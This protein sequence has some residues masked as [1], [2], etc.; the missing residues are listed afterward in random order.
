M[1]PSANPG[2]TLSRPCAG[3]GIQGAGLRLPI[4]ELG[5]VG[6]ALLGQVIGAEASMILMGAYTPAACATCSWAG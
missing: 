1:R 5:T 2:Q 4:Q 6:E 3:P